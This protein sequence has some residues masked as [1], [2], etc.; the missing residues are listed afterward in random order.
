MNKTVA[1]QKKCGPFF[2][3]ITLG[4]T[5]SVDQM[6]AESPWLITCVSRKKSRPIDVA[7]KCHDPNARQGNATGTH[8]IKLL[9]QSWG[10]SNRFD[11]TTPF[12]YQSKELGFAVYLIRRI[13]LL[14]LMEKDKVWQL[15]TRI[16]PVISEDVQ[17]FDSDLVQPSFPGRDVFTSDDVQSKYVLQFNIQILFPDADC[18]TVLRSCAKCMPWRTSSC[19]C[20]KL[21]RSTDQPSFV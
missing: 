2:T 20:W 8:Q 17:R 5:C 12:A 3:A 21:W 16:L 19:H 18:I 7:L 15:I 13:G 10:R 11:A 6:L 14:S 4:D 1:D 9:L